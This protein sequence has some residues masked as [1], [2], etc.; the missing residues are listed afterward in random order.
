[1]SECRR[2][3]DQALFSVVVEACVRGAPSRKVD[4]LFNALVAETDVSQPPVSGICMGLE[5]EMAK[6]CD[7]THAI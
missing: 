7:R 6:F 2:H 3:G 1:L 4:Y 5:A